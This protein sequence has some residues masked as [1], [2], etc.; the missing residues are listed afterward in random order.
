M[1]AADTF[2]ERLPALLAGEGWIDERTMLEA[3]LYTGNGQ[4]SNKF[5]ALNDVVISRGEIARIIYVEA[6]I[7]GQPL[8]TYK[9]DGVILATATGSTGR[10]V[11]VSFSTAAR[12][13][14]LPILASSY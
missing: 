6:T 12:T 11:T 9:A 5:L 4:A 14:S 8:T 10:S 7:D 13:K 2:L 1:L 3:E